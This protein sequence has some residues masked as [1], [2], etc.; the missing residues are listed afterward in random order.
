MVG[1]CDIDDSSEISTVG[2]TQEA[3]NEQMAPMSS[4]E[5]IAG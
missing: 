4:E 1:V 2:V 3:G 5:E